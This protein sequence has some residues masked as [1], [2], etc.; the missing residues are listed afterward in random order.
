MTKHIMLAL[1]N[2]VAGREEEFDRW[3]SDR[4]IPDMLNILGVISARRFKLSSAQRNDPP[5]AYTHLAI[6]EVDTSDLSATIDAIRERSGSVAMPISDAMAKGGLGLIF[7]PVTDG[8][9]P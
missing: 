1:S 4:H 3:Y 9:T 5:F 7:E 6:Y 2:F 8:L